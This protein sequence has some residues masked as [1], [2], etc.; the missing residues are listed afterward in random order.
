LGV[1]QLPVVNHFCR[2][3]RWTAH[4]SPVTI[5][6]T[7]RRVKSNTLGSPQ[8][9]APQLLGLDV[10][11]CIADTH[12]TAPHTRDILW[13]IPFSPSLT[14][15]Y[16]YSY[17]YRGTRCHCAPLFPALTHIP[18]ADVSPRRNRCSSHLPMPERLRRA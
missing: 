1:A 4:R 13:F 18:L 12:K 6:P 3:N 16:T 5:R 10:V 9:H 2:Q 7:L 11:P 15:A 8:C 17:S 14:I